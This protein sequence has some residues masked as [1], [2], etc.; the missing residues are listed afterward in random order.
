VSEI[1]GAFFSSDP[2]RRDK[3]SL[4]VTKSEQLK[5]QARR[6]IIILLMDTPEF[7][8]A[9]LRTRH[10]EE[11]VRLFGKPEL[12]VRCWRTG[13]KTSVERRRRVTLRDGRWS[14]SG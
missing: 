6:I 13:G 14:L 8:E 7:L 11:V 5:P 12:G 10:R 3:K 9:F 2:W 4:D 1:S